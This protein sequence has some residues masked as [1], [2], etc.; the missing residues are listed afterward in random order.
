MLKDDS[1][2]RA[3]AAVFVWDTAIAASEAFDAYIEFT[4][5]TSQR[6]RRENKGDILTWHR[7]GRSVLL[8]LE[9]ENTL[10]GMAPDPETPALIAKDF[11]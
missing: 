6:Q 5:Q 3:L 7:P 9:G 8:G 2:A 1:G 10:I 4:A 11:P